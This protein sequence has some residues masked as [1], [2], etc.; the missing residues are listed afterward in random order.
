[1]K[2]LVVGCGSIGKRHIRNLISMKAGSVTGCDADAEKLEYVKNELSAEGVPDLDEALRR[3]S[4]DAAFV[5]T[6]PS[7]HIPIA[8]KLLKAGLHCFIEKPLSDGLEGIDELIKISEEANKT[9]LLGYNLR[10]STELKKIKALIDGGAIGKILFLKASVGY[11]LPYWRPSEDYRKGYGANKRLGGGIV[12]DASH[13]IDFI[14]HI[15]GEVD[16]VFAVSKKLSDLEIDTE[17]FAE[18]ILHH[19][20]GA[21][22][23]I[24]F[25]YLQSHYRRTCEIIGD[26]GML[27]WDL[28]EN[29]LKQYGMKEKECHVYGEGLKPD[30][31]YMYI[32][33]ARHFFRCIEG[34]EEPIINLREGKRVQEIIA[35]IKESSAVNSLLAV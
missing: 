35:R 34:K 5:C 27:L 30:F 26:K 14:R 33:E 11:Y 19:D 12:L 18:V 24:H 3:N 13:E 6:P 15:A 2:L 7:L 23:Q 17:D 25:D 16:G 4:Y 22:S 29:I 1:M 31:N 21:F 8:I 9:V 28:N 20:N 10:Y 32:E